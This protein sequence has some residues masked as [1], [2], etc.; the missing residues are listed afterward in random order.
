[1]YECNF[2]FIRKCNFVGQLSPT[3]AG[4]VLAK[5]QLLLFDWLVVSYQEMGDLVIVTILGINEN[6]YT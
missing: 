6:V 3:L 5:K 2:F 1:M 4:I